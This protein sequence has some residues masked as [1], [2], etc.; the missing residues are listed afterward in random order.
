MKNKDEIFA[1]YL[2][3]KLSESE[4][5]DFFS[6]NPD[7]RAEFEE[8]QLLFQG[9]SPVANLEVSEKADKRF[10]QYLHQ[11]SKGGRFPIF[12]FIKYAAVLALLAGAYFLGKSTTDTPVVASEKPS[13]T[14]QPVYITRVDTVKVIEV[15]KAHLPVVKP[16][17]ESQVVS[18]EDITNIY[19]ELNQLNR[20]QNRMILAMLRQE[21]ASDRIHAINQSR[22]LDKIDQSL[23]EA[24]FQ[25][26]ENDPS[27]NVRLAAVDAIG[28]LN[29]TN[30]LREN[31]VLA[32]QGQSDPSVQ[33]QLISQLIEMRE[34]KALPVFAEIINRPETNEKIRNQAEFGMNILNKY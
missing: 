33:W 25:T 2:E 12:N 34:V 7:A 29:F 21:S 26:L 20:V 4:L 22:E 9:I 10:Y 6:Q 31:L 24:L 18:N 8:L 11:K 30:S 5:S 23:V 27:V 16:K 14:T 17:A 28:R 32:L 15:Q 19:N 13:E 3:G 1:E